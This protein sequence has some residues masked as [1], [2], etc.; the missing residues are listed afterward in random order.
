LAYAKALREGVTPAVL[1][2]YAASYET[3]PYLAREGFWRVRFGAL[4]WAR[5]PVPVRRKMIAEAV[6]LKAI[7]PNGADP[8]L[9]PATDAQVTRAISVA[10]AQ[11]TTGLVP[12]RR[13][14]R[15]GDVGPV[16]E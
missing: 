9:D 16:R 15:P 6:W 14:R 1:D 8:V 12:D 7:D 4:N 11:P 13:S 3:A 2:T 5:L 10:L